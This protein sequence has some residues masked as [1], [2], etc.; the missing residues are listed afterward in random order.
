MSQVPE[1]KH[2]TLAHQLKRRVRLIA[3]SL[4]KDQERA[5]ILEMLLSKRQGVEAVKIVPA[6]AS[7]TI[8]F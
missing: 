4:R 3:P 8:L 2:F 5:Y 1:F 6:I 7:V